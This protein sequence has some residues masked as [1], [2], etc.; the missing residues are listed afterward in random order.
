MRETNETATSRTT[1]N[2]QFLGTVSWPIYRKGR[3]MP[4]GISLPQ[5]ITARLINLTQVTR[6]SARKSCDDLA[7]DNT[8]AFGD[9]VRTR[10]R[11]HLEPCAPVKMPPFLNF[12]RVY[13]V[14]R[15]PRRVAR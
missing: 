5:T 9:R 10:N 12:P 4:G 8:L 11:Y 2:P 1:E 15:A 6:Q 14:Y 3:R 13:H 7:P